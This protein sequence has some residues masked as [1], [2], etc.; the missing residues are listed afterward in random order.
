MLDRRRAV[1]AVVLVLAALAAAR[2][3]ETTITVLPVR[4]RPAADLVSALEPY[5]GPGGVV[6][7]AENKIIVRAT[8]AALA[9]IRQVLQELDTPPRQLLIT[10]EQDLDRS[11]AARGGFGL[12][13][14]TRGESGRQTQKLRALEGMPA[15]ISVGR[16]APVAQPQVVPAPGG[17]TVV[18]EQSYQQAASGFYVVPRV[19]GDTVT[20]DVA[21]RR[22]A[23][24]ARGG[25]D[26]QR[27]ET[28][29]SGRLGEWISLGAATSDEERRRS[30]LVSGSS[31]TFEE[32]RSV[33]LKVEDAG[34]P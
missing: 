14:E 4:H 13:H 34:I 29:V 2:A 9:Q 15:F 21:T 3:D 22:D 31:A 5:A 30:G 20:L 8:P 24:D 25:I 32:L 11:A 12:G 1:L 27:I 10:V 28:T 23:F 7:A 16:E 33:R 19:S 18:P 17:Y 6:T 26:R